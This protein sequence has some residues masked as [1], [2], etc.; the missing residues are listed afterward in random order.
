MFKSIFWSLFVSLL[1]IISF[2]G[3][4]QIEHPISWDITINKIDNST[5]DLK[6]TASVEKKWHLYSFDIADGGP[7]PT[8]FT[9]KPSEGITLVGSIKT[10][11]KAIE[12]FDPMFDMTIKYFEDNVTFIQRISIKQAVKQIQGSIEFMACNDA[13]CLPPDQVKFNVQIPVNLNKT[14]ILPPI[15]PSK[16]SDIESNK[17]AKTIQVSP[18]NSN[19]TNNTES[20]I[21]SKPISKNKNAKKGLW[22]IFIGGFLG[23]FLALLTPCVFPMIP[24]TVS[25]FIKRKEKRLSNA[26]LYGL[27]II[28][29]YVGLGFI[30]TFLF[31][32][33]TMNA[34]S[35]SPWFNVFLFSLLVVFGASFLGA[36]ELQLPTSWTNFFDKKADTTSGILS[37]FFMAFTLGLVSFSCTGPIIGTLLVEAASTASKA[38]PLIGM[39]GF[40][41]ALALPFTFLHFF[42]HY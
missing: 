29:I 34:L 13:K 42:H 4:A 27:S 11:K 21:Q 28:T 22:L 3:F 5:F 33:D 19:Q 37:I 23:G 1:C 16:Q 32:P 2:N 24:L 6:Y 12:K 39:F 25:F 17:Q 9:I 8:S 30:T 10:D 41:L 15:Q 40:S 36:F 7:V 14:E 26:L 20:K 38:G 18:I 31:G 35:T